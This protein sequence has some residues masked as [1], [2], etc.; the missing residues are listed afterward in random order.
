[1][2][3]G[4]DRILVHFA[5]AGPDDAVLVEGDLAAPSD[6]P[7]ARFRLSPARLG[8]PVGCV[9]CVPRGPVAARRSLPIADDDTTGTLS[10]KLAELG[11]RLFVEVLPAIATGTVALRP[12][13]F[14]D[15]FTP[16]M[17]NVSLPV[18]PSDAAFSPAGNCSGSTP[19]P[20][21]LLR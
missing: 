11:A 7:L 8:H 4:D 18:S 17:W 15:A 12:P 6:R 5:P 19:I 21:R 2:N 16:S 13:P 14:S 20:T 10:V 9:C 1:M 3:P